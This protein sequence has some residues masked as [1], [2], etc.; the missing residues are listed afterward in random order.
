MAIVF[1]VHGTLQKYA[2][3]RQLPEYQHVPL[4]LQFGAINANGPVFHLKFLR[5][6]EIKRNAKNGFLA[7]NYRADFVQCDL[8]PNSF[9]T[10]YKN[11]SWFWHNSVNYITNNR[12]FFIDIVQNAIVLDSALH[13]PT[14]YFT[15][16]RMAFGGCGAAGFSREGSRIPP[17][18]FGLY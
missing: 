8:T 3:L 11:S 9:M 1:K 4:T 5:T 13:L 14:D 18:I 17:A 12:R 15:G 2:N 6:T 16:I 10:L 7:N